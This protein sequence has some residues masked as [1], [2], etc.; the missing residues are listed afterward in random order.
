V[1][2]ALLRWLSEGL[3]G[4]S[5]Q[6]DK[7]FPLLFVWSLVNTKTILLPWRVVRQRYKSG[8]FE[9]IV[10]L[11]A[12]RNPNRHNEMGSSWHESYKVKG[13]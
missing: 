7:Y 2:F 13:M 4:L 9:D 11:V 8:I 6:A 5:D 10:G 12:L 1:Y 3:S